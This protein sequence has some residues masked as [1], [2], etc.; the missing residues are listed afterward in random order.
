MTAAYAQA[1][2]GAIHNKPTPLL[3]LWLASAG[4]EDEGIMVTTCPDT[5][6]TQTVIHE[7]IARQANLAIDPPGT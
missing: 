5:G 2:T 7:D 6:A 1:Q 3:L 4:K